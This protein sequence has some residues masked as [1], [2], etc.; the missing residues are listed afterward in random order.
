MK[1]EEAPPTL[2]PEKEVS[3][4][5][6]IIIEKP[7]ENSK[8]IEET[9]KEDKK[10]EEDKKENSPNGEKKD[11]DEEEDDEKDDEKFT[12]PKS[13]FGEFEF[14]LYDDSLKP[15]CT[16]KYNDRTYY[17]YF[18]LNALYNRL[19]VKI[20]ELF[21]KYPK[22]LENLKE[23]LQKYM[24]EYQEEEYKEETSIFSNY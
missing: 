23:P 12:Y 2:N 1:D 10:E 7:E 17:V 9:K 18:N 5:N 4:K 21:K 14:D 11:D 8:K 13:L 16:Y 6:E 22:N 24:K 19:E 20:D 15:D 3:D